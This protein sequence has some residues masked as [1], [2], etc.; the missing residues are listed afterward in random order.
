MKMLGWGSLIFFLVRV[1]DNKA[2][3]LGRAVL[4]EAEYGGIEVL[5]GLD[6]LA[7]LCSPRPRHRPSGRF[8]LS[9]RQSQGLSLSHLRGELRIGGRLRGYLRRRGV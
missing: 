7:D 1:E 9:R 8:R 6:H 4:I 2:L 5:H 3:D